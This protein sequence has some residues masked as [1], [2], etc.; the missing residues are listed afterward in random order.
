MKSLHFIASCFAL[1]FALPL[2]A[3]RNR[4][5]CTGVTGAIAP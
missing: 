4:Q 3:A 5:A 2:F 1:S